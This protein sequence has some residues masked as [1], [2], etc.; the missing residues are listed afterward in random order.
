MNETSSH[1]PVRW[2]ILGAANIARKNW[3]AILN[4]GN[5]LLHAVASRD[6]ERC[7]QFV[8]E[9]QAEAPFPREPLV[10][11]S[12]D[13]LIASPEIEAVYIPL[14]TGLRKQWVLRAA[15]AGKHV[16]CEKPCGNCAEDVR[17]MLEACRRRGVQF[18]DG[19]MFMHSARLREIQ[20]ILEDGAT[21]GAISRITS[22]FSAPF[23]EASLRAGIR[24]QPVMEPF[25][26]LG[27][28]GW[29]CIR[30][31]LWAM[32]WQLPKTVTGRILSR[33]DGALPI[34]FS[35]ELL[36]DGGVSASFYCSFDGA[37]EQWA[38]L[39]GRNGGLY[40]PDF[41]LPFSGRK[42][43]FDV[44]RSV[45]EQKGCDFNMMARRRRRVVNEY[46]NS[47]SDSQESAMFR[48][49][50]QTVRTGTLNPDWEE[51]ALKTQQVIDAC[52][53]A[54]ITGLPVS[55]GC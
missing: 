27:D 17:E 40:V 1:D 53:K 49:F 8:S 46:S 34:R 36:F 31:S 37:N 24:G 13:D 16:I 38:Y 26:C 21:I 32:S 10:L 2:G 47:H 22:S 20:S 18:M 30:L 9:C 39:E 43:G 7:R 29:Y 48:S 4:S 44:Y 35:A 33:L 52:L 23:P 15:Q 11:G 3:K 19:V 25:G 45:Y 14:P 50:S 42:T 51:Y 55:P 5:G 41:V 12:Y 6:V 54:A 28:L